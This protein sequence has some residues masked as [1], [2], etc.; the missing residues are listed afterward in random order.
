MQQQRSGQ[1]DPDQRGTLAGARHH[2]LDVG[3]GGPVRAQAEAGRRQRAGIGRATQVVG[4][5]VTQVRKT[6]KKH[7]A[8]L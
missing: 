7:F 6:Q 3:A 1:A 5:G 8:F 2:G 4:D